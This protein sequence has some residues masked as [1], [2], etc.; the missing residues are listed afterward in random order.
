MMEV[1]NVRNAL[2]WAEAVDARM[3]PGDTAVIDYVFF[4]HPTAIG[5]GGAARVLLQGFVSP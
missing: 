1:L 3:A 2:R 5:A 4:L